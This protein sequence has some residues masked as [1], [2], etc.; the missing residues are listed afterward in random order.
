M[1]EQP[2]VSI[3]AV[4]YNHE[5]FVVETLDSI[6]G[7]TYPN[8]EL[9]IMDD[10]STDNSVAVIKEWIKR[11]DYNCTFIANDQNQGVCKNLNE[12][13][14]LIKG[15]YYQ[16]L[17]CDDIILKDKIQEQVTLFT[18]LDD[19]YA[20]VYSDAYLMDNNS[21]L[22]FGNFIQRH[23]PQMLEVPSGEVYD[24]LIKSNYIPAMSVL[25]KTEF[26]NEIDGYDENLTYED[27]D[28]WLRLS[29]TYKFYFSNIPNSKYRIHKNNFHT[30]D[31][32][33]RESLLNSFRIFIKHRENEFSFE[34]LRKFSFELYRKNL[35]YDFIDEIIE[36]GIDDLYVFY[37][38]KGI[39]YNAYLKRI[40]MIKLIEKIKKKLR[41]V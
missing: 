9:L 40:K 22:H 17:S 36:L 8:I 23:K 34:K 24:E 14:I 27:Y 19:C 5:Q 1:N 41:M 31:H 30:S 16:C 20:L 11:N 33:K 2:L 10:Y 38:R 4:C 7:Q 6:K 15:T 18:Q 32:F 35:H 28:L 37:M 26:V 12:A 29:K 13:L 3:V 21:E 25:I 39:E